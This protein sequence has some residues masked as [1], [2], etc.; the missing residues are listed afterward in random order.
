MEAGLRQLWSFLFFFFFR[1]AGWVYKPSPTLSEFEGHLS[2]RTVTHTRA[3]RSHSF[4]VLTFQLGGA[5]TPTQ[6]FI[7]KPFFLLLFFLLLVSHGSSAVITGVSRS[8]HV[9]STIIKTLLRWKYTE[10]ELCFMCSFFVFI[11][12]LKQEEF[13][14]HWNTFI[15]II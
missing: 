13:E 1:M 14:H 12:I 11:C 3:V 4:N 5:G 10:Q 15:F 8:R 2:L 7:M 9:P 6:L